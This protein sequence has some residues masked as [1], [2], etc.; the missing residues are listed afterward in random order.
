M[1]AA[2][3]SITDVRGIR[4][5]HWTDARARTG[6]TVIIAEKGSTGGVDVRGGAPGTLGTDLLRPL[7]SQ[8]GAHAILLTGGSAFGLA[9]AAGVMRWCEEHR[10]GRVYR[11]RLIPLVSAAVIFDL[12]VG[13]PAV[14]P[15]A[16]A[17]YAACVAAS[18]EPPREGRVGAGTGATIAKLYGPVRLGGVGTAS[19]RVGEATVGALFVVNALGDVYADGERVPDLSQRMPLDMGAI[20]SAAPGGA[21]PKTGTAEDGAHTTIGVIA[22]DAALTK[23]E[24]NLLARAGHDGIAIAVRPAHTLRDGDTTFAMATGVGGAADLTALQVAAVEATA[25]AI[26]RAVA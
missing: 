21:Q 13:D 26:R 5:G 2:A 17:G 25:E 23:V 22:T 24:A 16:A 4:V 11:D 3:G 14:R 18:T 15:D 12:A 10:I 1:R 8:P 6:C 7:T 9:A 20:S 19:R